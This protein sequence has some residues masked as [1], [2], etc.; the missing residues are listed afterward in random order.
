MIGD[1]LAVSQRIPLAHGEYRIDIRALPKV[2]EATRRRPDWLPLFFGLC[3]FRRELVQCRLSQAKKDHDTALAGRD[4]RQLASDA[5]RGAV[6]T[7][8]GFIGPRAVSWFA[9]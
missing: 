6:T 8:A 3:E 7:M 5:R 9:A 2:V 4:A 1:F